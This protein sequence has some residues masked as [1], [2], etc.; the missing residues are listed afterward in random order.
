MTVRM[1][2]MM[3]RTHDHVMTATTAV[4]GIT[5][6]I[7]TATIPSTITTTV[8]A[9]SSLVATIVGIGSVLA[10][11]ATAILGG[12]RIVVHGRITFF[13]HGCVGS[14]AVIADRILTTTIAA[15]TVAASASITGA[16]KRV[17]ATRHDQQDRGRNY[18]PFLFHLPWGVYVLSY[19]TVRTWNVILCAAWS[20]P[21]LGQGFPMKPQIRCT[22]REC[23]PT[24]KR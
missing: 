22:T 9:T 1:C 21:V 14:S 18:H 24:E 7:A 20:D 16:A 23:I 19:S 10:I 17:F 11:V 8:A 4:D 5:L 3:V 2:G 12:V 13:H 6:L 15:T